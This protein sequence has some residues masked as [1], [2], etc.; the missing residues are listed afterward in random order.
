MYLLIKFNIIAAVGG[1]GGGAVWV[2]LVYVEVRSYYMIHDI[3]ILPWIAD[4]LDHAHGIIQDNYR[5][6]NINKCDINVVFKKQ[7]VYN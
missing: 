5:R 3:N 6:L 1:V 2:C 7:L 4:N